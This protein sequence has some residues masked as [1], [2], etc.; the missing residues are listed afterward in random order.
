MSF[1]EKLQN[2]PRFVRVQILLISVIFT[3]IIIFSCWLHFL[4]I[5]LSAPAPN[6]ESQKENQSI[7]SLFGTIRDDFNFLKNNIEAEVNGIMK[8]GNK[9]KTNFEVE[10]TTPK[11]AKLPE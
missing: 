8:N 2:K 7:P 3:M 10:I 11:P 5:S 1:I 6:E 9:E 4:R